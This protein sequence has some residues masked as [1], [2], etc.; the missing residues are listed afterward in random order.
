MKQHYETFWPRL[1]NTNLAFWQEQLPPLLE[2]ALAEDNNGNLSRWLDALA[3]IDTYPV[4]GDF[5]L[6]VDCVRV[7]NAASLSAQQQAKLKQTLHQFEPWRKGPFSIHNIVIDTEWRSDW[8]WQRVRPH[9]SSLEG[10]RLLDVGCGSGYHL[11]RMA[12][13]NPKLAVGIDPSLLFMS[14]FLVLKHF[15]GEQVPAY[16]LPLTLE[17]LPVSPKGGAFDTVFSMGVLY[18]RRSPIEHL[19]E[20]R[21]QLKSGGELVLETLVVPEHFGNLLVPEDRYAQ[22]RNVWFI[23]SVSELAKW[24]RRSGFTEVRCV[25][26]NQTSIQEQRSTEWMTWNSLQNF[27]DPQDPNL[28]I[29][30]YPAPLRAVMVCKRP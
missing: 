16:F 7:G 8:K 19:L 4:A 23:P 24:L 25:D 29:E 30:G 10:K 18:H 6:N 5:D 2:T 20:L 1:A 3:Q 15:I 9:L 28:T 11:W 21:N 22:M 13:E 27:L 12:G 14:Q 17:Q 26:L